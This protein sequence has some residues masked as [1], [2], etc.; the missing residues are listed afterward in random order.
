MTFYKKFVSIFRFVNFTILVNG[1]EEIDTDKQRIAFDM[2]LTTSWQDTRVSCA[3]CGAAEVTD[4]DNKIALKIISR[5][6]QHV[7]P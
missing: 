1:I 3:R 7:L 6:L 4:R 5:H 2:A